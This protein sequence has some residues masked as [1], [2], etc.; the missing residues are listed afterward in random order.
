M[1]HK[2]KRPEPRQM[3]NGAS[4]ELWKYWVQYKNLFLIEGILYRK[5]Q[6][7]PNFETVYQMV[8]P[9]GRMSNVLELLH[10]SPSAGHFG[11]EKTYKRACERFYWPCMKRDVRN[12][13]ESCEVCLK[14][15]GTKQKHRHS[16]TK[17]K[18]SHPFWQV[19]LDIMGPFP[20]SQ[21]NKYIL[22]IGDQFSKW[23]EAVALTNQEAKTVAK[24]FVE[25]WIVRFGCPVN[26]HSDQG[27]NFMSK[28]FGSIGSEL[29]IQRTSTTSYHPQ[30]NAIERTNRTIEECFSKYIGQYQHDWTNFLPLAM[31]AHRSSIHSVTRYS[32]AFVVLGF[33]LSLPIDCIYSTPQ[34]TIYATPSDYVST[35]KQRLQ[36]THQLMREYMDVEQERQKSYYDRSK[37]GPS[38]KVGE[39]LVFNPTVKKGETRK[40][41]SF[42]R[43]PYI[44]VEIINDLNFK[45]EDKKT[46][47]AIKVHYDRLKKYKTREK[48][49]TPEPQAKRKTTIKEQKNS[50][51]NSSD[52]GDII[53][54]ESSTDSESNLNTENQSEAEDANDSLNVTNETSENEAKESD[55]ET[56]KGQEKA[57]KV[58]EGGGAT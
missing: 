36:E 7:E 15:K 43:G 40:F 44:N 21:G 6:T 58:P 33:P 51:L 10:D 16:L 47:K 49:F 46:R 24:A 41:T 55:Q 56:S 52:D 30:G 42:Y 34:T 32:R 12:W 13:I 28:L 3:R 53:E 22:L 17:C 23:Y 5:H 14:R 39:M 31:M 54:I 20:E 2:Q 48:P 4:K 8:E 38:Y 18:P 1:G 57:Q 25:H 11:I 26:L 19:S 27:S 9:W 29:G 35:M 50:D 45:V 37:Y